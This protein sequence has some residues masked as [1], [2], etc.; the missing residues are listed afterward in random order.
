M[1]DDGRTCELPVGTL[2][3][4]NATRALMAYEY[5]KWYAYGG[6]ASELVLHHVGRVLAVGHLLDQETGDIAIVGK[7]GAVMAW[8]A[9]TWEEL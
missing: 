1:I 9:T 5:S 2:L 3:R 4:H 8:P 6:E 7:V